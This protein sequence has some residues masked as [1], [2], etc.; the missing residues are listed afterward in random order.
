MVCMACATVLLLLL[1]GPWAAAQEEEVWQMLLREQLLS[2]KSCTLNYTTNIR[3]FELGGEQRVDARAH[4]NDGRMFD[5]SWQPAT[6]RFEIRDCE[7]T[8]C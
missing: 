6:E 7:P 1:A 5:V 4:C 2:E 3:K 8:A